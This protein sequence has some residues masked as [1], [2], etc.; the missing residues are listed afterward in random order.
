MIAGPDEFGHTAELQARIERVGLGDL[1]RFVGPVYGE[2]RRDAFAAAEFFV[3]PSHSEGAPMAAL[4]ALGAGVP[5]LTT[6]G[7]PCEYLTD[8]GLRL[9]GRHRDG[10]DRRSVAGR[11]WDARRTTWRSMGA[12]GRAWSAS[13]S[14]GRSSPRRPC[15]CTR[16]CSAMPTS[17]IS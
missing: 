8:H 9:V 14:P 7:A 10:G 16:G 12:R 17:R 15:G 2:D 11:R 4:E 5:V 1:V 13:D 3:L 6:R